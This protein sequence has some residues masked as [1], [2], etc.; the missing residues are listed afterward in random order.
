MKKRLALTLLIIIFGLAL[1]PSINMTIGAEDNHVNN[2]DRVYTFDVD[3]G[4]PRTQTLYTS[5]PA[6]LYDY[7]H[8]ENHQVSSE[9]DYAK[10]VTPEAV[11]TIAENLRKIAL[12]GS[13]N[14]EN[15]AND[16]LAL[17]HQIPYAVSDRKYPVEALVEN[18]GDCDVSSFLAASILKAGGL[19][20][21]LLVYRGLPGSHMNVGVYLPQKPL[22]APSEVE[23]DGFEYNNKTYWVAE[24]TPTGNW[25]VGH[26]SDT[27]AHVEPSIIPLENSSS[28]PA[29]VSS[30][31]SSPLVPSSISTTL[32]LENSSSSE[33]RRTL[34]VSGS[35]SPAYSGKKVVMYIGQNWSSSKVFQTC[36]DSFGNYSL[37]WNVTSI[38]TYYIRTSLVTFSN[39]AGSDSD[40][41]TF[42]VGMYPTG[43]ERNGL[44]SEWDLDMS[45]PDLSSKSVQEF[46]ENDLAGVDISLSGEFMLMKSGQTPTSGERT[47]TVLDRLQVVH[48]KRQRIILNVPGYTVTLPGNELVNNQLGFTLQ[49]NNGNYS[50]NVK[51]S[52]NSGVIPSALNQLGENNSTFMNA[53][54]SIQENMWYKAVVEVSKGE[55][56]AELRGEN[57]TLLKDLAV[58]E[59]AVGS[60]EYGILISCTPDTFVAFRNL[61]VKNLDQPSDEP[62]VNVQVPERELEMLAPYIILLML[63]GTT[64]TTIAYFRKAKVKER[65]HRMP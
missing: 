62:E 34:V 14:D 11:R 24:C 46:L 47:I 9:R 16:V 44:D 60:S 18:S 7:Y 22:P 12:N 23:P 40:S 6:S 43:V 33:N 30:S 35:I 52:S 50:A 5:V 21:V 45:Y 10:F 29:L 42:F 58:N 63:L 54:R 28:S 49:N 39:Y 55:I 1:I 32:S 36:T 59:D 3:H 56:T 25:K 31:L 26:Q 17:V 61:K 15:F 48:W 2:Y 51:L 19:D 57:G 64:I 20:V 13:N 38:G 53:S 37:S 41:M 65:K 8:S 27:F 4:D